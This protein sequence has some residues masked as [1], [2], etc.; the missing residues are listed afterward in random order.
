MVNVQLPTFGF[1]NSSLDEAESVP[2]EISVGAI[3]R[4]FGCCVAAID[5]EPLPSSLSDSLVA[6]AS[7]LPRTLPIDGITVF[8]RGVCGG[9]VRGRVEGWAECVAVTEGTEPRVGVGLLI[10]AADCCIDDWVATEPAELDRAGLAGG[11]WPLLAAAKPPLL[12][13]A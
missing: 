10:T 4:F 7:R 2:A 12:A 5:S 8:R 9:V 11:T 6:G 3:R 13:G 1:W